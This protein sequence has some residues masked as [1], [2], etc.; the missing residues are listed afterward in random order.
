[1]TSTG[2]VATKSHPVDNQAHRLYRV[3]VVQE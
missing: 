2:V 1:V 3:K